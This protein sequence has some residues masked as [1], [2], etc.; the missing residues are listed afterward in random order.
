MPGDID[1]PTLDAQRQHWNRTLGARPEMFGAAPS[2]PGRAAAE[3]FRTEGAHRILELGGGQGRDTFFLA[4]RGFD[5]HVLDYAEAGVEEIRSKAQELKLSEKVTPAKHDVRRALPFPDA[6]FDACYSHMLFCMALTT[7]EIEALS[8]E[9]LRVLKPGGLCVYTTRN[10]SDADFGKGVHR[11]DRMYENQGFIV[12]FFDRA[13][14]ERLA[15]GYEL[16]SVDEFEEGKLPRRLYRVTIR[17][18]S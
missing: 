5:V 13:M 11:G 2:A 6:S 18:P 15:R 1:K 8:Q 7:V 12:H 10:T 17:K 14:V 16:V 4:Q 9:I 3:L